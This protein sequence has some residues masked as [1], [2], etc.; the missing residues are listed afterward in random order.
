[1]YYSGPLFDPAVNPSIEQALGADS[2][3]DL[4]G[5][6]DRWLGVEPPSYVCEEHIWEWCRTQALSALVELMGRL[7]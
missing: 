1:M 2:T 6:A 5:I 7:K 3:P 4:V